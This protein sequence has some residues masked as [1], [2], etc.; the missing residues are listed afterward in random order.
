[1]VLFYSARDLWLVT[2]KCTPRVFSDDLFKESAVLM[3]GDDNDCC[4]CEW[5]M[6]VLNSALLCL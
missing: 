2:Q 4:L 5:V 6:C 1:M 3:H